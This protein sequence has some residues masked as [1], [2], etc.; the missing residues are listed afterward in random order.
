[1]RRGSTVLAATLALMMLA[2]PAFAHYCYKTDWNPQAAA[3]AAG[4]QAWLTA[5]DWHW[6]IDTYIAPDPDACD[7]GLDDLHAQIDE[8]PD[9]T[10]FMGPGLLA[11]GTLH[12]DKGKTPKHFGYIDFEQAIALCME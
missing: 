12:N 1:M 9:T 2:G 8:L 6:I 10:L 11:G 4:S 7:E 3:K 5:A